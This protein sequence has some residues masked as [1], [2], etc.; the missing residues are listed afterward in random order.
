[1]IFSLLESALSFGLASFYEPSYQNLFITESHSFKS[2]SL[3][4]VG[5]TES[6][7]MLGSFTSQIALHKLGIPAR[8]IPLFRSPVQQRRLKADLEAI[9][10]IKVENSKCPGERTILWS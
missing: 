9:R 2:D 7:F 3:F 6:V 4:S 8:R 1:S 10:L 5:L